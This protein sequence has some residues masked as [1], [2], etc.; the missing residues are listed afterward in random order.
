[1]INMSTNSYSREKQELA[2][3][4]ESMRKYSL[5]NWILMGSGAVFYI[6]M[7]FSLVPMM[8]VVEMGDTGAITDTSLMNMGLLSIIGSILITIV[9][10][11]VFIRSN[12]FNEIIM[13]KERIKI[14]IIK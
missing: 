8:N 5:A 1:M 10:I 9:A 13:T 4:G 12:T 2:I 14:I 11:Y 3:L 7:I 6:I